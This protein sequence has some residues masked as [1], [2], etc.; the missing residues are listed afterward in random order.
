MNTNHI[1]HQKLASP[2]REHNCGLT[3][4]LSF[5]HVLEET[6]DFIQNIVSRYYNQFS[7]YHL[8]KDDIIQDIHIKILNKWRKGLYKSQ[9]GLPVHAWIRTIIFHHFIDIVRSKKF[10]SSK[11]VFLTEH[12]VQL[13]VIANCNQTPENIL[14]YQELE[15]HIELSLSKLPLRKKTAIRLH[16]H[17]NLPFSKIATQLDINQNTVQGWFYRWKEQLRNELIVNYLAA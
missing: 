15:Y 2:N 3:S 9:N 17:E 1:L 16:L 7:I 5:I 10:K 13:D 11:R 4:D 8:S 6:S 12:E 14:T